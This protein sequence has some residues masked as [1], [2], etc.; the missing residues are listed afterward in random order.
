MKDFYIKFKNHFLVFKALM[1]FK[2]KKGRLPFL[3][4][5]S[6]FEEIKNITKNI[7]ENIKFEEINNLKKMKLF[8]MKKL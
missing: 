3:N 7:Y 1:E 2:D 8:L 4:N 6:D 5:N